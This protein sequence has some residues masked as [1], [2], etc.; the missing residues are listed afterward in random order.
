MNKILC[1]VF[2]L[3]NFYVNAQVNELPYVS[4]WNNQMNMTKDGQEVTKIDGKQYLDENFYKVDLDYSTSPATATLRYN[5][6]KDVIE[7]NKNNK[8]YELIPVKDALFRFPNCVY[9][10]VDYN[11]ENKLYTGFLVLLVNKKYSLYKR[12]KI[13]LDEG[14]ISSNSYAD[15]TKKHYRRLK[16]L[17]MIKIDNKFYKFPKSAKEFLDLPLVN[18]NRYLEYIKK[19]KLNFAKEG[20]LIKL[21]DFINE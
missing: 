1:W 8:I 6:Y 19:N 20:D 2:A 18:A 4:S 9:Q 7:F 11:Y 3:L 21:T 17:N 15:N 12:E 14:I 13:I 10:Y 16:D 5:A